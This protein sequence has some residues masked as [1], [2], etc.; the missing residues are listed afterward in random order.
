MHYSAPQLRI[1]QMLA[2]CRLFVIGLVLLTVSGAA[3]A[4]PKDATEP[5]PDPYAALV[6]KQPMIFFVAKGGPDSCGPGCSEWIAAEG[7]IDPGAAQRFQDFLAGL[8]RRDLPIFFSSIGG[9]IGQSMLLAQALRENRMAASV[10][11]TIAEG[12]ATGAVDEACRRLMQS[13]REHKARLV[14]KDARCVSACVYALLGGSSRKVAQDA[15]LG[16]HSAR[17]LARHTAEE[18]KQKVDEAHYLTRTYVMELGIDP[19]LIDAAAKVSAD[20]VHFMRRDE[21]ARFGIETGDYFET[22]WVAHRGVTGWYVSKSI[23]Q[24]NSAGTKGHHTSTVRFACSDVSGLVNL[25]MFYRRELL[26]GDN[27]SEATI[28]VS[29]G[30]TNWKLSARAPDRG[31]QFAS[32]RVTL[33]IIRGAATKSA[34]VITE[35]FSV[36]DER[37]TRTI[38]FSTD[39]L[40]NALDEL[41]NRCIDQSHKRLITAAQAVARGFSETPWVLEKSPPQFPQHFF[42]RKSVTQPESTGSNE[43]RTTRITIACADP[44]GLLVT[45]RRELSKGEGVGSATMHVGGSE[46]QLSTIQISGD[47]EVRRAVMKL[48]L[49]QKTIAEPAIEISERRWLQGEYKSRITKISTAGLSDL[50]ERCGSKPS[51]AP[52]SPAQATAR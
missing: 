31:A 2:A 1:V 19:G 42:V 14:T 18:R 15:K 44:H 6:K 25:V 41:H 4:P 34:I 10:G 40:S 50:P 48:D 38:A 24:A 21:I 47:T 17:P 30:D 8:P 9:V 37:R 36:Q 29:F 39:G 7:A 43:Y 33:D 22:G 35:W 12:C 52:D 27:G 51:A 16:I 11:R 20:R 46:L 32:A 45:Y 23:T 26:T 3:A 49:L 13:K 28:G 5:A